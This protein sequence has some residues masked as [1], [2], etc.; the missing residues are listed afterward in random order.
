[1]GILGLWSR[2]VSG[3]V[4][5]AS[6]CY[7]LYHPMFPDVAYHLTLGLEEQGQDDVGFPSACCEY[8]LLSLVNKEAALAYGRVE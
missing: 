2:P 6:W 7:Q 8:V 1:M 3:F 4:S 5:W